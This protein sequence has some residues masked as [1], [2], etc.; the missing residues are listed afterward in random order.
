M[1]REEVG[2]LDFILYL[3]E[4]KL[5]LPMEINVLILNILIR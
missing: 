3:K 1:E 5:R 2:G 4:D